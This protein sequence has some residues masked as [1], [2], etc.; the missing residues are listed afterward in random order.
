[1]TD[2]IQDPSF[3]QSQQ[4]NQREKKFDLNEITPVSKE[5][6]VSSSLDIK[7]IH[8][9]EVAEIVH[10]DK[11]Q[12]IESNSQNVILQIEPTENNQRNQVTL[13]PNSRTEFT[14]AS[15]F[16]QWLNNLSKTKSSSETQEASTSTKRAKIKI[17]PVIDSEEPSEMSPASETLAALLADQGYRKEAIAMY[18][19]L[20]DRFPE[21]KDTFA[22]LIQKLKN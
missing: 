18:Q 2:N 6:F 1:M 10:V 16:H 11:S 9:S 4:W 3:Q 14:P 20:S 12:F 8:T 7:S 22:A 5:E 19:K 21:K 17:D 13:K 15:G